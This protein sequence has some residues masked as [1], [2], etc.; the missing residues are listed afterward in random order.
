MKKYFLI[1]TLIVCSARVFSQVTSST[2]V[3]VKDEF[4]NNRS[5]VE[6]LQDLETKTGTKFIY[7]P[8]KLK[9]V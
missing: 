8:E 7:T 4:Y 6:I 5:M 1:A 2:G 3:T 9:G